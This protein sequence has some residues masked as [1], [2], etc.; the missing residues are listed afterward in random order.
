MTLLNYCTYIV[1][2]YHYYS[3][4]KHLIIASKYHTLCKFPSMIVYNISLCN[5]IRIQSHIQKQKTAV[6]KH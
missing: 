1:C 5:V 3:L 2:I 4:D 6:I